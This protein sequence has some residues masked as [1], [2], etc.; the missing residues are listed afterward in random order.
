MDTEYVIQRIDQPL[1][2]VP[3]IL[4]KLYTE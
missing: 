2:T 4:Y 1:Q 3:W